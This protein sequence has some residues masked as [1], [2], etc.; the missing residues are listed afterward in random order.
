MSIR[1]ARISPLRRAHRRPGLDEIAH[2]IQGPPFTCAQ[3]TALRRQFQTH[4]GY[5]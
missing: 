4:G 1:P 3:L 5:R 2:A